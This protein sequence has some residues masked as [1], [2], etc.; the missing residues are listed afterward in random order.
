MSHLPL[1]EPYPFHTDWQIFFLPIQFKLPPYRVS[2][3]CHACR[4]NLWGWGRE[5]NGSCLQSPILEK[6][7]SHGSYHLFNVC[8]K[9]LESACCFP[10]QPDVTTQVMLLHNCWS[11]LD[12]AGGGRDILGGPLRVEFKKYLSPEKLWT[13]ALRTLFLSE[14]GLFINQ[15]MAK[16]KCD[17]AWDCLHLKPVIKKPK[18]TGTVA[19]K[20]GWGLIFLKCTMR[21]MASNIYW[22]LHSAVFDARSVAIENGTLIKDE[23]PLILTLWFSARHG[24]CASS[25]SGSAL[26]G[27]V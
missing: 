11:G 23:Q 15:D 7:I 9:M 1:I 14:T 20:V 24:W 6:S 8:N 19:N 3:N 22:N 12:G 2:I 21:R 25:S 13:A 18:I 17:L 16:I 27:R 26:V 5:H 10:L 4:P